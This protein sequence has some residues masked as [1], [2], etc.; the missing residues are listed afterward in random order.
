D[1]VGALAKTLAHA[2][3]EVGMVTPLYKGIRSRFPGMQQV[4]LP[5][6]LPLAGQRFRASLWTLQ[7]T[8]GLTVYFVE[9]PAFYERA[10]L[11]HENGVDYPDNA[12]R[13]I[14]FAKVV[15]HL[16]E[17]LAWKP[18]VLHLHDWQAAT[19]AVLLDHEK[20]NK[21]QGNVPPVCLTIHNLAYQGLFPF[22]N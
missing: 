11:Y 17:N 1:M 9:Q 8:P 10:E 7:P 3:H 14:F 4:P 15:A 5:L 13:F 16:A 20:R 2:G 18:D 21:G 6:E 22:S 12:A 19:A